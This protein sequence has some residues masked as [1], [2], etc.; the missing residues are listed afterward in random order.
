MTDEI[1][2]LSSNFQKKDYP[3]ETPEQKMKDKKQLLSKE[4]GA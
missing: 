3:F 4:A 1:R 2:L